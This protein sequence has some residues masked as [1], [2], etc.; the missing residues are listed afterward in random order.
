MSELDDKLE[1]VYAAM[2]VSD[3]RHKRRRISGVDVSLG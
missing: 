3:E 1:A 2:D